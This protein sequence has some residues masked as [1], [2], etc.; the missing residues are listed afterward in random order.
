MDLAN[1]I[2]KLAYREGFKT[3]R[4]GMT[5]RDL[6][7]AI[8]DGDPEARLAGRRR[9]AVRPEHGLPPRLPGH[10]G[11]SNPGDAV[12]VDGGC[13][14]RGLSLRRH[15]DGRLRQAHGQ[16]EEGLGHRPE[17][18]KG[19]PRRGQ[20]RRDLRIGRPGGPQSRRGRGI[21]AGLQVL[22][23]PP[24]PRHRHGGA[25][26]PLSR[27]GQHAQD[28]AGHDLQQRARH[29]HLRR[30]RHPDRGLHGR[31]GDRAPGT[32]EDS[33]PSRSTGRSAPN[34]R[35]C[36]APKKDESPQGGRRENPLSPFEG[37]SPRR[38][39]AAL[40]AAIAIYA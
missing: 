40:R 5:T 37:R 32:S 22:R 17:S 24:R 6:A 12:L 2:T 31:H 30:V 26:V 10:R 35:L 8:A 39:P 1:K 21:R 23:P 16:A 18:P 14:H 33:K 15:P 25:R 13:A 11:T 36:R 9:A 20:A 4:E 3:L 34:R 7:G 38:L 27:Q 29:L 28:R 19:G